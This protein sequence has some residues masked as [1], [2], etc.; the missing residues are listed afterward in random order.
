MQENDWEKD[1]TFFVICDAEKQFHEQQIKIFINRKCKVE[2]IIL[3]TLLRL[4]CFLKKSLCLLN[5][6]YAYK[7][8][9][10]LIYKQNETKI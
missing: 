8:Y 5:E 9:N 3:L 10:L 2:L 6:L 1:W 7:I 4:F